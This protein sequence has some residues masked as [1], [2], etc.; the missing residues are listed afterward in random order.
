MEM[1]L[2]AAAIYWILTLISEWLQARLEKRL[3]QSN[4]RG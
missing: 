3:A 4:Q 1:L 2:L